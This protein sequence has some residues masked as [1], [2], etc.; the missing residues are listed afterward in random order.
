MTELSDVD[1]IR[2]VDDFGSEEECRDFLV[3]LRRPNGVRAFDAGPSISG[4]RKAG[5]SMIA[6]HAATSSP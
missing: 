4:I 1:L 3:E 6:A 5:I 2:L